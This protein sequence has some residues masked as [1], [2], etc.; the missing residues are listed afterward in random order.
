ME[1]I[2]ITSHTPGTAIQS[3]QHENIERVAL[4]NISYELFFR[5]FM[6]PNR[7]V[8][9]EGIATDWECFRRWI[10]RSV[11]PPKLDVAYLKGI[12]PN[13]PVPVADCGKQHYNSH[14]KIEL[15]LHDF[16]EL[17][18]SNDQ[19]D[20]VRNRYYL[21]DWHLRSELPEF[22]FYRT[23]ALFTSDWLNEYLVENG[24]DDYRF[25]YI[26]PKDTWTAFH[27]DVFGSYSWSVNI[28][29][30]KLWYMLP[31]GEERKLFNN[32]R[33]LP[34]SVTEQTLQDAGVK[35]FSIVQEAGEAI[36]VPSG[37]YHQ[38][39]NVEDAF[40]VNHNWFN[41]CNVGTIWSNLRGALADVR[42]EID[43][44]RD[45][46]NFDDHCQVMLK[47]SFGMNYV[48]FLTIIQYI[49]D[50]R[51]T[52]LEDNSAVQLI[53]NYVLG[54]KHLMY[55]LI[56]IRNLLLEIKEKDLLV[57]YCD[58]REKALSCLKRIQAVI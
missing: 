47:A 34:F 12:L 43:D 42:R 32:L 1:E 26:G 9:V 49:C 28:F 6:Q 38:V 48:D 50:K 17:W 52:S 44:C 39:Q 56:I 51:L 16:L 20:S 55:D 22:S 24:S 13:V 57:S 53:D 21:K 23:P 30:R 4:E 3:N 14:E 11:V 58:L 5:D 31:P 40:S 36:F 46:D 45:M 27:A 8:V 54:R 33:N 37:W 15:T 2:E 35:F 29:G 7:A 19:P 18:E 41:G 25:V 10:D